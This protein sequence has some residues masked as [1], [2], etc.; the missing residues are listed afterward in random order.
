MATPTAP[1]IEIDGK[2]IYVAKT[3]LKVGTKARVAPADEVVRPMSKPQRRKLR[4]FLRSEGRLD[5]VM[6]S[7][8]TNII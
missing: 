7:L 5:L 1:S 6:D 3:G 4:K 8:T 2:K